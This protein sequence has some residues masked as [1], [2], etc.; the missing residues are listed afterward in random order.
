[1]L[2]ITGNCH[3]K[4]VKFLLKL[5]IKCEIRLDS[6]IIDSYPVQVLSDPTIVLLKNEIAAQIEMRKTFGNKTN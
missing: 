2:R 5:N 6:C 4:Q 1:M 3:Q